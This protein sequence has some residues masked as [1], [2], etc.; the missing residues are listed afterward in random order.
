MGKLYL[1]SFIHSFNFINLLYDQF[2][3]T[4]D[5]EPIPGSL[6]VFLAG[7]CIRW[8]A[9][10][11][12]VTMHTFSHVGT[13]YSRKATCQYVFGRLDE[14][15]TPGKKQSWQQEDV[16]AVRG[17]CYTLHDLTISFRIQLQYTLCYILY[18]ACNIYGN[19]FSYSL[20]MKYISFKLWKRM[21]NVFVFP[22]TLTPEKDCS[23]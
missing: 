11:S 7:K 5:P 20:H 10:L 21:F 8:D 3:V 15:Q 13:I 2:R 22:S 9:S 16:G 23:K 18:P 14:T 12:Q 17:P 19:E 4:V 6:G 1:H